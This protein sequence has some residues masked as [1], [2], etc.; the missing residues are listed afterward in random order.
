MSSIDSR[1]VPLEGAPRSY[2][3][4]GRP[5]DDVLRE[6]NLTRVDAIKVDVE[7]AEVYVL[8]GA[9]DTLKRFHPKLVVEVVPE[10]LANLGSTRDDLTSLIKDAGYNRSRPLNPQA[11]DWEWTVQ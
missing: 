7:G 11:T 8:R 3:V 10:Q 5:I 6:L 9:I 1:N 4:R 2:S